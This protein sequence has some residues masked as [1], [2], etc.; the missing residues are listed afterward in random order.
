MT[1][2]FCL[3]LLIIAIGA[4][5]TSLLVHFEC[6]RM[7]EKSVN[8]HMQQSRRK[9]RRYNSFFS[10]Y[11]CH[12]ELDYVTTFIHCFDTY[13]ESWICLVQY[14]RSLNSESPLVTVAVQCWLA[15]LQQTVYRHNWSPVSCRSSAGQ[16]K[17]ASQRPTFYHCATQ[18]VE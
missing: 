3:I 18:P 10:V 11:C 5:I 2:D 12:L 6:G 15:D 13:Y 8:V 14:R 17:F 1:S 4:S 7:L 16:G 9:M